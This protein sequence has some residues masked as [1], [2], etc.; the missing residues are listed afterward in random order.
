MW[1]EET[2]LI[3]INEDEGNKHI[4]YTIFIPDWQEIKL[5]YGAL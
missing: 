4:I 3:N 5:H 2:W 1:L